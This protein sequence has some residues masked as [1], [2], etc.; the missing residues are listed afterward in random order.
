MWKN[1]VQRGGKREKS[2]KSKNENWRYSTPYVKY[3]T[4][5]GGKRIEMIKK[6]EGIA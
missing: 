6:D 1:Q 2:L 5:K 4:Q 3:Q